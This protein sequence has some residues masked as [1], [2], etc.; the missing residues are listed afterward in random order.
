VKCDKIF[1]PKNISKFSPN[2]GEFATKCS[3]LIFDVVIPQALA[4]KNKKLA[5]IFVHLL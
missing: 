4:Q 2:N 1:K 3:F 5:G